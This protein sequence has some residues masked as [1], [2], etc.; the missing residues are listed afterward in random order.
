MW[1][2]EGG[3]KQEPD[4]DIRMVSGRF[5]SDKSRQPTWLDY[6]RNGSWKKGSL[7]PRLQG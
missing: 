6:R 1:R 3:E 7:T 5:T 4:Q 2:E